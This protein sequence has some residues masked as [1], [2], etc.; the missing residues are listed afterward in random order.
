MRRPSAPLAMLM[1]LL[2]VLWQSLCLCHVAGGEGGHTHGGSSHAVAEHHHADD[3][4]PD[5][6][7]EIAGHGDA[8]SSPCDDHE[9][10]CDCTKLLTVA[11]KGADSQQVRGA[12]FALP[13]AWVTTS[14]T[15]LPI[16][17]R[18]LRRGVPREELP[19]PPLLALHCQLLI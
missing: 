18:A 15:R 1:A 17:A 4:A 9:D 3:G 14:F 16:P 13:M 10:G 6:D 2:V 8:P 7:H 11:Q 5:H 19:P 12:T